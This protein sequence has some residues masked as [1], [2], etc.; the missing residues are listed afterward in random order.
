MLFT[1]IIVFV[2]SVVLC[3][4]I[5]KYRERIVRMVGKNEFAERYLGPGGSYTFW[6]LFAILIVVIATI[7]MVG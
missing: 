2:L 3:I 6:V 7:W 5:L 1:K 4:A